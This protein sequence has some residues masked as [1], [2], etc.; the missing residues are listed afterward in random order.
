[1]KP[2]WNSKPSETPGDKL[3]FNCSRRYIVG[4]I[5]DTVSRSIRHGPVYFADGTIFPVLSTYMTN[6]R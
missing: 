3:L 2:I 5:I 1:M 4:L 6:K